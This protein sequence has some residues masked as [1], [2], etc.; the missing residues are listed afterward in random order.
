MEN[1]IHQI[2][3]KSSTKR[4]NMELCNTLEEKYLKGYV[5]E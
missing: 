4:K 1:G 2:N 5:R 3:E